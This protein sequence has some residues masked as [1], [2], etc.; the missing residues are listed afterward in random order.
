V[1]LSLKEVVPRKYFISYE[2]IDFDFCTFEG[3][4]KVILDVLEPTRVIKLHALE[5]W[6]KEASVNSEQC[7]KNPMTSV[8]MDHAAQ[9]AEMTFKDDFSVGSAE[10]QISF[11][12]ILN[13]KLAGFYRSYYEVNG[14]KRVMATTQMEPTDARRAFPC[15][16]EPAIKAIF[17]LEI[18]TPVDRVVISN[19]PVIE[20]EVRD[21]VS[22]GL[23]KRKEKVWRFDE[24]PV[25]STYLFAVVVGEFDQISK[26]TKSGVQVSVY[27]PLGKA[28]QG[29]FA[30]E[31][32][33]KALDLYENLYG[34]KYPLTKS[35]LLAIPDFAAGAM[36]NWGCVTY[37]EV[38]VLVSDTASSLDTK[39]RIARTI[40][41]ELAH[42]WFGNLVTMEWWTH[43][44]LNEGFARFMEFIAVTE[45]FPE[46]DYWTD[47]DHEVF[48]TALRVDAF[49]SSHP[50]EV[51]VNHPD[52]IHQIFDT[53]SYAKG[54]S[55][56]RMISE[57]IGREKFMEGI[58]LYLNKFAY[59]NAATPDLWRALEEATGNTVEVE[60]MAATWT[61]QVGYPVLSILDENGK[62]SIS[63]ERFYEMGAGVGFGLD[64][65]KWVIPVRL[66]SQCSDKERLYLIGSDPEEKPEKELSEHLLNLKKANYWFKL[67]AGQTSF[68][69]TKYT[70]AQWRSLLLPKG[71]DAG[72][73]VGF[74]P[75][76]SSA[77]KLGLLSDAFALAKSGYMS[78][79]I[80]LEIVLSM[81]DEQDLG[82]WEEVTTGISSLLRL[83]SE[84]SFFGKF[85]QAIAVL[86]ENIWQK[87]GFTPSPNEP[88]RLTLLRPTLIALVSASGNL[89][90]RAEALGIFERY[91]AN[92]E[93]NPIPPDIRSAIFN[94]AGKYG[95]DAAY[96]QIVN[97][98]R[99]STFGEEKRKALTALGRVSETH[100]R[101]KTWAF[102]LGGEVRMQDCFWPI[103][104]L[105]TSQQGANYVWNKFKDQ[106]D[107][108]HARY[109]VAKGT[110][111]SIVGSALQ[112]PYTEA[113]VAEI[114]GFL[115]G[116]TLGSA[117]KQYSQSLENLT[118]KVAQLE[119]DRDAVNAMLA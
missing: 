101:E 30:L 67:N 87:C 2:R 118:A 38:R 97:L 33:C 93:Q 24:T 3:K 25:M 76:L 37:R 12:G 41:H 112:G 73:P 47:F 58:R 104:S 60:K 9:T 23:L 71:P 55:V 80:Y 86:F 6:I 11:Q 88:Q 40:C 8:L 32:A 114:K 105:G 116:R 77:D 111:E 79:A 82:V 42:Q 85:Q 61:G 102:A 106:Y 74:Q 98:Y 110:W 27:T 56:I 16:D 44:W 46:W 109:G 1:R 72:R 53:I 69:R 119:R 91:A 99:T 14:E 84:E 15:W 90:V 95:G 94:I 36:E 63:Q 18:A 54:A 17:Q 89:S 4:V 64:T 20:T 83:Y 48:G 57:Y 28:R 29:A 19:T 70:T 68:F 5:L 66:L 113:Q 45:F 10:L 52:E 108:L 78:I 49:L 62:I 65:Q 75:G 96:E 103:M 115:E 51:E 39:K 50:I 35:D 31:T 117:T 34:V 26:F 7:P 22:V 13:D 59:K 100:L 21:V 81:K 92:P 107:Y 43:L